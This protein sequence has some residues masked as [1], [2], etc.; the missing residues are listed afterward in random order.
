MRFFRFVLA[1]VVTSS[2]TAV[3]AAASATAVVDAV[4]VSVSVVS[5]VVVLCEHTQ[6]KSTRARVNKIKSF[7]V[8][9]KIAVLLCGKLL[10]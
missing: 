8:A 5:T 7:K 3:A 9:N 6:D 2:T 1:F 10:F 4:A